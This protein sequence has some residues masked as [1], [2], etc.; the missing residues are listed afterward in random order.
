MIPWILRW[1]PL[2]SWILWRRGLIPGILRRRRVLV[3]RILRVGLGRILLTRR[4]ICCVGK[5][6]RLRLILVTSP[7]EDESSPQNRQNGPHREAYGHKHDLVVEQLLVLSDLLVQL[8]RILPKVLEA[9]PGLLVPLHDVKAP[10]VCR[11]RDGRS[12][13]KDSRDD[14]HQDSRNQLSGTGH[15]L[16]PRPWRSMHR[17][18]MRRRGNKSIPS[19]GRPTAGGRRHTVGS[20]CRVQ[21]AGYRVP[22]GGRK[23]Y[24]FVRYP[25]PCTL[26][27]PFHRKPF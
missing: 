23:E 25:A 10:K 19:C 21:A 1:R 27:P 14:Q 12:H 7:A 4:Q 13:Q 24:C 17:S 16:S 6:R 11:G 3:P 20:G 22:G 8:G 5:A 9:V 18:I 2:I 15:A 26:H